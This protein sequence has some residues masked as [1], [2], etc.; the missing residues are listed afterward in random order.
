[1]EKINWSLEEVFGMGCYL[2]ADKQRIALLGKSYIDKV[3]GKICIIA[4]VLDIKEEFKDKL[5]SEPIK[6][7]EE[8]IPYKFVMIEE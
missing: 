2:V 7:V 3:D 6:F 5:P 8:T 1:M 4:E